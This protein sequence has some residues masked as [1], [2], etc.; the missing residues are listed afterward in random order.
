MDE[1]FT[2]ASISL[3][4]WTQLSEVYFIGLVLTNQVA[5]LLGALVSNL[6]KLILYG[7]DLHCD[8]ILYLST[9]SHVPHLEELGLEYNNLRNMGTVMCDIAK[10][11]ETISILN[12]KETKMMLHEKVAL[13]EALQFSETLNTLVLHEKEDMLS[14]EGYETLVE[15]ACCIESLKEFYVFPF[16]YKPFEMFYRDSVEEACQEILSINDRTDLALY[17]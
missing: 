3:S 15:M 4:K 2:R 9:C 16:D 6:K 7:C 14:T 8:D 5:K 11:A 10:R 1:I 12:L 17:Y 13:L